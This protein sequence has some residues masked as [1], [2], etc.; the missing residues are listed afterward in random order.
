MALQRNKVNIIAALELAMLLEEKFQM[1]ISKHVL[2]LVLLLQEQMQ[3]L[4]L[5]SGSINV[6]VKGLR[7]LMTYG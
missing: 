5:V 2:I 3:K 6:S 7:L 1:R 4:H